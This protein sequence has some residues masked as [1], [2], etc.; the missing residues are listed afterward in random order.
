GVGGDLT[1]TSSARGASSDSD[2][3][4]R[5]CWTPLPI[6]PPR[7]HSYELDPDS[8]HLDD[9]TAHSLLPYEARHS[10]KSRRRGNGNSPYR[11]DDDDNADKYD[12]NDDENDD[13][14][15]D[16]NDDE[17]FGE[18]PPASRPSSLCG[19]P[20]SSSS[21]SSSSPS[22]SPSS[23][24]SSRHAPTPLLPPLD[25]A[26]PSNWKVIEDD[27]LSVSASYQTHLGPDFLA[28]PDS[29]L[30]D[31]LIHLTYIRAGGVSRNA[32]LRLFL[33]TE[34]GTHLDSPFVETAKVLAFRLEPLNASPTASLGAGVGNIMVD[35][36]RV[37]Y[38]AIQGQVLAG[39]AK[40]MGIR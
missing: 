27:F 23:T 2:V 8:P 4:P 40:I 26:V 20:A 12:E 18:L 19:A 10:G 9:L 34:D 5:C 36:E 28:A 25:E 31:G 33:S 3:V 30:S 6:Q 21:P 14:N 32:L 38:G 24:S 11:D 13:E 16:E 7:P 39:V 17:V 29:R 22:S 37:E 35:G 15:I 1:R